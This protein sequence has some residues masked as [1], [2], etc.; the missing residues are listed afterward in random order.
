MDSGWHAEMDQTEGFFKGAKDSPR[1]ASRQD[2]RARSSSI[3]LSPLLLADMAAD[4]GLMEEFAPLP[5]VFEQEMEETGAPSASVSWLGS[6][7]SIEERV[8]EQHR[9]FQNNLRA[10]LLHA[11]PRTIKALEPILMANDPKITISILTRLPDDAVQELHFTTRLLVV[12]LRN[13]VEQRLISIQQG[14]YPCHEARMMLPGQ[15]KIC[16]L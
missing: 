15:P 8:Y 14:R 1:Y 9:E 6:R 12:G 10:S 11:D 2:E 7:E 13:A 16:G 4:V 3:E 5:P